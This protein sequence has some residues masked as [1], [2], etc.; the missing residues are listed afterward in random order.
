MRLTLLFFICLLCCASVLRTQDAPGTGASIEEVGV[1]V[2][3]ALNLQAGSFLTQCNCTFTDGRRAGLHVGALYE[4]R[5]NRTASLS[6]GAALSYTQRNVEAS[7]QQIEGVKPQLIDRPEESDSVAV[8]FR[9]RAFA[10]FSLITL[11]PYLKWQPDIPFFARLGAGA[12]FVINATVRHNKEVMDRVVLL[13]NG[14]RA[15]VSFEDGSDVMT[16]EDGKFP[17]VSAFQLTLEPALGA[18]IR[19][20]ERFTLSPVFQYSFPV[21]NLSSRGEGFRIHSL[22]FLA[23][24][25]MTLD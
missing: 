4:Y 13:P 9:H 23:E 18:N 22:L 15:A 10:N 8:R 2:G 20:T 5:E 1:L 17:S 19:L 24:L 21:M 12:G 11:M 3:P 7:Y 6:W 14:E 16:V 25:R